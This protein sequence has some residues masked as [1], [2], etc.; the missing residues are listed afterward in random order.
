MRRYPVVASRQHLKE[1]TL[2]GSQTLRSN[3]C[4]TRGQFELRIDPGFLLGPVKLARV[5]SGVDFG[6]EFGSRARRRGAS[7]AV[8][9][10]ATGA[11]WFAYSTEVA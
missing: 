4:A 8:L 2:R 7:L 5:L 6:E 9:D 3:V 1:F 11:S 10:D